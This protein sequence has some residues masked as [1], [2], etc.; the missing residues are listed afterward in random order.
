MKRLK[1]YQYERYAILC[2]ASYPAY[3]N[4]TQYGFSPSGRRDIYDRWGRCIIRVLW[5]DDDDVVVV[6]RGSQTLWDWLVNCACGPKRIRMANAYCCV[7]WGFHY[8]LTQKSLPWQQHKRRYQAMTTSQFADVAHAADMASLDGN[9]V[10]DKLCSALSPLVQ[11]NKK[12]SFIGHSSGGAMAVLAA[13]MLPTPMSSAIKRIVTF[14]Q[15]AAGM[16]RFKQHYPFHTKTYRICCDVDI[17]TFLPGIPL[18]YWHVGRLLWLHE[19]KIYTDTSSLIRVLRVL[20]SW[21]AR[22]IAYHYMDKYI[23]RKDYFDQH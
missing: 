10:L 13:A 22:P 8:L 19:N 12:V 15:P 18:L 21:L 17:I 3:F 20:F 11:A 23:R 5:R 2:R 4:H 9:T 16:W 1:R 6:F 7:H 14:G